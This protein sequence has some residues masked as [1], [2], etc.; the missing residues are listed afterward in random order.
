LDGVFHVLDSRKNLVTASL[1]HQNGFTLV[2]G[3]NKIVI[4]RFGSYVGKSHL[5]N[6][7]YKLS[8][9][10]F[11]NA[12]LHFLSLSIANVECCDS[13]HDRLGHVNFNTIKRMIHL[14]LKPKSYINK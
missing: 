1:L 3:S 2:L 12:T 13:R 14:Y 11:S 9:M 7:L 6:G 8:L 5:P 4:S 10:P